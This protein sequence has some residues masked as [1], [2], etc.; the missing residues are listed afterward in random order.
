[1]H[2][3]FSLSGWGLAI[4]SGVILFDGIHSGFSIILSILSI[5]TLHL[6]NLPDNQNFQFG[7]MAFQRLVVALKS[8]VI[9][10][11]CSY[12]IVTSSILILHGRSTSSSSQPGML[13]AVI[14]I[15]ACPV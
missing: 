14:P 9:A 4:Q 10:G 8:I 12:G 13:Y 7:H 6:V 15:A 2:Y 3:C 1:V 11:V 5:I